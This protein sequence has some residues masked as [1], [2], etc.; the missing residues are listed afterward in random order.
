ML[1]TQPADLDRDTRDILFINQLASILIPITVG[2]MVFYALFDLYWGIRVNIVFITG[3]ALVLGLNYHEKA[4][5]ARYVAFFTGCFQILTISYLFGGQ[6]NFNL[7]FFP[8]AFAPFFFFSRKFRKH[9]TFMYCTLVVIMVTERVISYNQWHYYQDLPPFIYRTLEHSS[10]VSALLICLLVSVGFQNLVRQK[11]RKLKKALNQAETASEA[12]SQFL[13]NISHEIRTPLNGITGL[14]AIL[15]D[16]ATDPEQQKHLTALQHSGNYLMNL[17]NDLLDYARIE[18]GKV[19]LDISSFHFPDFVHSIREMH[20]LAAQE[21]GL[22]FEIRLEDGLPQ[23]VKGDRVRLGQILINLIHNAIKF[24]HQGTVQVD[25]SKLEVSDNQVRLHVSV[26][27]EGIGIAPEVQSKLTQRFVQ[28]GGEIGKRYGGTGLGLAIVARLLE[29]HNSTLS[30]TSNSGQGS[31]FAFELAL[32]VPP[33]TEGKDPSK[34][35]V[36]SLQQQRILV[37]DD[38]EVNL[39]VAGKFLEKQGAEVISF[40]KPKVALEWLE[41]PEN[42]VNLVL[43]DLI[44]PEMD[45]FQL[46][47]KIRSSPKTHLASLPLIALTASSTTETLEKA[48]QVGIDDV[49]T[50]PF[51][52][53]DLAKKLAKYCAP[54]ETS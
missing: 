29:L 49:A 51:N 4:I 32:E 31:C 41:A 42:S 47:E 46:A 21:K 27:D 33:Q 24:S 16:K 14:T 52:R 44:M 45:G 10:F 17:V 34:A 12:K 1:G 50:K 26:K 53:A 23:W 7:F 3:Y 38:N 28:A 9:L 40:L 2:Y 37:V 36:E 39:M 54:T 35:Q 6:A 19:K 25:I 15:V 20:Y 11:E 48:A 13:S 22:Q 30:I 43:L 18:A 5:S 8:A